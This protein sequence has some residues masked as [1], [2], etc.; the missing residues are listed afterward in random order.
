MSRLRSDLKNL[1]EFMADPASWTVMEFARDNSGKGC[2]NGDSEPVCFCILGA[3]AQLIPPLK[4]DPQSERRRQVH[5][6][7]A[8]VAVERMPVL[9]MYHGPQV[10]IAFNDHPKT[11]HSD[12]LALISEAESRS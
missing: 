5:L 9:K 4:D 10:V 2:R 3:V 8:A 11:T 12:V 6:A 7:L 1:R